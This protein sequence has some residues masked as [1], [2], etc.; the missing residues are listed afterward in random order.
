LEVKYILLPENWHETG[1]FVRKC[2]DLGVRRVSFDLDTNPFVRGIAN[3]LTDEIIEGIAVLIYEA[4]LRGIS[5]YQSGSGTGVWQSENGEARVQK[6]LERISGGGLAFEISS[7]G[8]VMLTDDVKE[9][10]EGTAIAWGRLDNAASLPLN[11]VADGIYLQEDTNT[12]VHRIEQTGIPVAAGESYTVEVVSRSAGRSGL[13]IEFRD[14][15][16]GA[17]TRAKYDLERRRVV[18]SLHDNAAIKAVDAEWVRCQLT[19]TPTSSMAVFNV[20]LVNQEGLHIYEG[21]GQAGVHIQPPI[22]AAAHGHPSNKA[23]AMM[24]RLFAGS[25]HQANAGISLSQG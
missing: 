7:S 20:T 25:G 17:Y 22:I 23:R 14:A 8:F 24:Q 9:L 21:T 18:D 11:S 16:S 5:V 2:H 13:M 15:S 4:K 3:S 10:G 6:A 19:L 1:E 12:S